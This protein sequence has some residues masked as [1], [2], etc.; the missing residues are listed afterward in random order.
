MR[1]GT[2]IEPKKIARAFLGGEKHSL[3]GEA[4]ALIEAGANHIEISGEAVAVLPAA[5]R[6]K[7]REEA[8][9][10][11]KALHEK[12]GI[13][14]S[15]HLPFMGGV[16]FTTAIDGIREASVAVVKEI[17]EQCAPL[18]PLTYVLHISGL[19]EDLMNIGLR[20]EA[21]IETYLSCAADSLSKIVKVIPPSKLCLENLEYISFEKINPLV[22]QFNTRICMD[23]G[24]IK[25]RNEK[26][27]DFVETYGKRLGQ[28]H[29]HGVTKKLFDKRVTILDDHQGLE[30][31]II[32]VDAIVALLRSAGFD[33]PVVLE[34]HTVDPIQSVGM[35]REAVE[36]QERAERGKR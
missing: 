34:V 9:A 1:V 8:S 6:D 31:G 18:E 35:L 23:V 3:A 21:V 29:L 33:G 10:G 36:R 15:V 32:D 2:M 14:F 22:E 26:V 28:V 12:D 30:S 16:N 7:F 20:N 13:S 5:L 27:E 24:H 4:R 19:L 11:L 17:T 25:L